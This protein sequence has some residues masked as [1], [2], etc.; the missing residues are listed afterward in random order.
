MVRAVRQDCSPSVVEKDARLEALFVV[1]L[2][3]KEVDFLLLVLRDDL[4]A[5]FA[6][7][8]LL[9]QR[10]RPLIHVLA[11]QHA[12]RAAFPEDHAAHV[13]HVLLNLR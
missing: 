7:R 9:L 13:I 5:A 12:N 3:D 10:L 1:V 8:N 11:L 2:G 6:E 4:V